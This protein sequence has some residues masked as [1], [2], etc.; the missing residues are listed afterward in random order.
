[1][2]TGILVY[3]RPDTGQLC[4]D[5]INLPIETYMVA[6]AWGMDFLRK[7]NEFSR[8]H[9]WILRLVLGRYAFRE[10]IGLRDCI[11]KYNYSTTYP[12]ELENMDYHKDKV[13][14]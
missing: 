5:E 4:T 6:V 12:Y 3:N 14:L 13:K 11:E 7:I 8:F 2:R 10:L 1:M 9:K